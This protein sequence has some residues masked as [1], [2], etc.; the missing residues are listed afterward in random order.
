[1]C[2]HSSHI[3]QW[4]LPLFG[5]ETAIA[6]ANAQTTVMSCAIMKSL[7]REGKIWSFEKC[8]RVYNVNLR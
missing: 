3:D 4:N 1:M 5:A 7:E 2:F 8:A 6:A